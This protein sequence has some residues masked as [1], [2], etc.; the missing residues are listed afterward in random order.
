MVTTLLVDGGQE[1][2]VDLLDGTV[3]SAPATYFIGW[4]TGGS[5]T[6]GTV[7]ATQDDLRQEATEVRATT[8]ESQPGSKI[9]QWV[10]T[11]QTTV[12]KTIE[13]AA[14]FVSATGGVML[15]V[16]NHDA[17]GLATDDQIQYT[18][19]LTQS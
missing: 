3:A 9:N 6:L 19:T 12:T 4:G 5:G 16:G 8:A 15:I 18:V 17:V 11:L 13:E 1:F 14:L 10:G 2:I 7:T